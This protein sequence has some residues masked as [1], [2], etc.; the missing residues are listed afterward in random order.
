MEIVVNLVDSGLRI[1]SIWEGMERRKVRR[2]SE[3]RCT[4]ISM[5]SRP[6]EQRNIPR[7]SADEHILLALFDGLSEGVLETLLTDLNGASLEECIAFL[8]KRS[9]W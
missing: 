8:R 4:Q 6:Q 2:G 7:S 5:P 3:L 1:S 9:T